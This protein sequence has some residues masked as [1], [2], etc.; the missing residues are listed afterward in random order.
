MSKSNRTLA[1]GFSLIE[2]MVTVVVISI[3]SSLAIPS[4]LSHVRKA[5]RTE[6]KTV[7]LDLA[8][9]EE[10][11]YNTNNNVYT[12]VAANL[13]YAPTNSATLVTNLP[14]LSNYYQV[15]ITV[16]PAA[17]PA[18]SYLITA[19]PLSADQAKDIQCA[20]FTIDSTGLQTAT[21]A[22]CWQ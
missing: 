13:G 16:N 3:L 15:T 20:Q 10:R 11:Y 6:A 8:G 9:R 19:T 17:I 2:L 7:L 12:N 4:Y 5:R 14:V 22:S 1:G 21:N 18:P